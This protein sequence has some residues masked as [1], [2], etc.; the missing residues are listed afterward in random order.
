MYEAVIIRHSEELKVI[1][2]FRKNSNVLLALRVR[3]LNMT[4]VAKLQ[5]HSELK[6]TTPYDNRNIYLHQDCHLIIITTTLTTTAGTIA[7]ST[8]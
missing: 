4:R 3:S 5:V 8:D 6:H 7:Y 1:E 2:V